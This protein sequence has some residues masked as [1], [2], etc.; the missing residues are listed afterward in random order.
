MKDYLHREEDDDGYD[1]VSMNASSF[2][3]SNS[4]LAISVV[5]DPSN[6]S[7]DKLENSENTHAVASVGKHF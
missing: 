5:S 6:S 2:E 3:H 1:I 7:D 4:I